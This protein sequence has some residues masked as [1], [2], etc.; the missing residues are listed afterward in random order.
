MAAKSLLTP[1]EVIFWSKVDANFP[2]CDLQNIFLI[3]AKEFKDCLGKAFYD[4][5]IENL[6]D[7]TDAEHWDSDKDYVT[8]DTVVYEGVYY[9]AIENT[10]ESPPMS[11]CW[12]LAPKFTKDCLNDLWCNGFLAYY[13]SMLVVRDSIIP[14]TLNLGASGVVK[15]FGDKFETADYKE[16]SSLI[17]HHNNKIGQAFE[18]L[19][20]YLR[21]ENDSGCFDLYK[22]NAIGCCGECGC[23]EKKCCCKTDCVDSKKC[24]DNWLIG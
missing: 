14:T 22:G 11:S 18:C 10:N 19:D 3:L 4:F 5:L 15:R 23:V 6:A 16:V 12:E 9:T 7:Y 17:K 24:N 1:R 21:D 8:G 20:A 2:T 13:L